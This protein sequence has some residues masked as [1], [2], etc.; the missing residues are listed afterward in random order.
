MHNSEWNKVRD[1]S[2]SGTGNDA[3]LKAAKAKRTSPLKMG[4]KMKGSPYDEKA[5]S[6]P[7]IHVDMD[8]N[9]LG[10][11]TSS[12]SILVNN[13]IKDPIQLKSVIEHEK[14]HIDQ[15]KRHD[16]DYDDD[17]VYWKGKRYSREDMAEGAK[18]LPWEKEAYNKTK[19]A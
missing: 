13:K 3:A 9:T 1:R 6:T 7:I 18:N 11:A 19:N 16:L 10:M 4:F 12:G 15:I 8:D 2:G 5:G 17:Y 14:V